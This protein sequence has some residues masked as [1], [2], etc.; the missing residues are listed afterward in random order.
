[1]SCPDY[2]V[3]VDGREFVDYC[4]ETLLGYLSD[5]DP[6]EIHCIFSAA[7]HVFRLGRK[8]GTDLHDEQ[9]QAWWLTQARKRFMKRK[10]E[11]S[12]EIRFPVS[13]TER[14]FDVAIMNVFGNVVEQ[15]EKVIALQRRKAVK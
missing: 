15:R 10:E 14:R 13:R 1:V 8:P 12:E 11:E 5:F 7:E 4:H 6:M 9:A 2:Y 3:L